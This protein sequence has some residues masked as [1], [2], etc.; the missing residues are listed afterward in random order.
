[1]TARRFGGIS[2][3][4]PKSWTDATLVSLAAP[5][6]DEPKP[7]IVISRDVREGALAAYVAEQIEELGSRVEERRELGRTKRMVAGRN[8]ILVDHRFSIEGRRPVR[9]LHAFID[10]GR[11]WISVSCTASEEGFEAARSDFDRALD[12]LAFEEIWNF[13]V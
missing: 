3:D 12:S 5:S 8:A 10:A 13:G 6:E 9:Q 4:V 7:N 2:I 11:E 1:M